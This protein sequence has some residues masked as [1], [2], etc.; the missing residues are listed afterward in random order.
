MLAT[1]FGIIIAAFVT[2]QSFPATIEHFPGREPV[3]GRF[4][5]IGEEALA[6][7][8]RQYIGKRL[9]DAL[10]KQGAANPIRYTYR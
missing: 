7:I 4:G 1:R 3:D 10:R 2:E 6:I 8:R 9:P 5:F